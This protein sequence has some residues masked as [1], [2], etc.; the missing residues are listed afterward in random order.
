MK[1]TASSKAAKQKGGI[2]DLGFIKIVGTGWF[3]EH[4]G[5]LNNSPAVF[6]SDVNFRITNPNC[7]SSIDIVRM[8]VIENDG[9]LVYEGKFFYTLGGGVKITTDTLSPHMMLPVNL[10]ECFPKPQFRPPYE[11]NPD[12]PDE[13]MDWCCGLPPTLMYTLEIAYVKNPLKILSPIG[14]QQS[15]THILHFDGTKSLVGRESQMVTYG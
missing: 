6:Q 3:G 1:S 14:W 4:S 5:K 8:S 9:T 11:A 2:H 7:K 10:S 15:G 12:N 13:W